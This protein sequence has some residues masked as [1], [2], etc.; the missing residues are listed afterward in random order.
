[1]MML[2]VIGCVSCAQRGRLVNAAV[3]TRAKAREV[4]I[5]TTGFRFALWFNLVSSLPTLRDLIHF[6][7]SVLVMP[8]I[9]M[10]DPTLQRIRRRSL[11]C[12]SFYNFHIIRTEGFSL[13]FRYAYSVPTPLFLL[14]STLRSSSLHH[15]M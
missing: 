7:N 11:V 6:A 13:Y 14:Y 2:C 15:C 4:I 5:L 8:C 1:V 10:M 12:N 9:W 3:R